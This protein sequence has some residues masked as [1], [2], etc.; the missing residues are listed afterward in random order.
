[1][2]R[3]LALVVGKERHYCWLKHVT[4]FAFCLAQILEESLVQELHQL[5]GTWLKG[6]ELFAQQSV[7]AK[8]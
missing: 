3:S 6:I 7:Q 1:M 4:T 5:I 8:S 2:W